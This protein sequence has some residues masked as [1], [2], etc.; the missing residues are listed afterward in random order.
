VRNRVTARML[1]SSPTYLRTKRSSVGLLVDVLLASQAICGSFACKRTLYGLRRS[2]Y[3]WYHNIKNILLDL[4]LSISDHDQCVFSGKLAP[5]LPPLYLGL[6]VDDFKYFSE[7]DE[8]ERLFERLLGK[9]CK[10]DFMGEVSWFLGCK[11]EWENLDDGRLTVSIPQTAKAEDLLETHGMITCNSVLSPYRSGYTIDGIP[12]DGLP[13][14][15]KTPLVK[16]FQSLARRRPAM[17]TTAELSR[18]LGSSAL[19][20]TTLPQSL[21]RPLC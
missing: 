1:S 12:N 18:Y 20:S 4:G 10:V 2:P 11:Y 3:H 13:P 8:T 14:K 15:Q 16:K 5:H 21:W 9:R 6:Y 7:S 19:T 17:V